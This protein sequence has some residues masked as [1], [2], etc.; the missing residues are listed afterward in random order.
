MHYVGI[1]ANLSVRR[2][3]SAEG[4]KKNNSKKNKME[5]FSCIRLISSELWC[6]LKLIE[7]IV[8]K[9]A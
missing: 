3:E 2:S 8:K 1:V 9:I 5:F 4:L 7:Y 6:L